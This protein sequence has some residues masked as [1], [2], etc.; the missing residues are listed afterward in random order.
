MSCKGCGREVLER[1]LHFSNKIAIKYGYCDWACFLAHDKEGTEKAFQEYKK[2][3]E[4]NE[5]SF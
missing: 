3:G 5:T 1:A 4:Q 2:K